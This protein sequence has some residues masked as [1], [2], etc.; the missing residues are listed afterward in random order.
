MKILRIHPLM[1]TEAI[2]PAA[3]GMART[4][5][6]LT[7]L[8]LERGHDVQVLPIPERI[9]SR[10]VWGIAP[11][12][13]VH[14]PPVLDF[15]VAA[16]IRWLPFAGA[17]LRPLPRGPRALAYDAMALVG[18][19]RALRSFQPD[20]V[21]NHLA[22]A[23][24]PRLAR[25][26]PI[27]APLVLTHHH[28]AMGDMLDAYDRIVFPSDESRKYITGQSGYPER[29]TRCIYNAVHP[30][31]RSGEIPGAG[32]RK[33]VFFVGAVRVRKGIDILLDAYR[34]EPRL[35]GEPLYICGTG[36]DNSLVEQ[37]IRD[38]EFPIQWMG[39]ISA[40]ETAERLRTA[41]LVVIPSRMETLNVALV[42]ALCMGVPVVGWAPT[43]NEVTR[44]SGMDVGVPFD[45]RT[46]S[47]IELAANILD[48]LESTNFPSER[49]F[50]ISDWARKTFSEEQ[51]LK[52]YLNLYQELL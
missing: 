41:K 13:T 22:R 8:L 30:A 45:G 26:L 1:K 44:E 50:E 39:R 43:V 14:V 18:L 2:T 23:P 4:S 33:G 27:R 35:H 46:Q 47:G 11:G 17:R 52:G 37:A 19:R 42:E 38:N 51:F 28:G 48:T 31:F 32:E 24:F 3:G 5:L 49:R 29:N 34:R 40:E 20:I 7:R 15:P 16:D 21:H 6:T 10:L 9:G 12:T 25:A 36:E